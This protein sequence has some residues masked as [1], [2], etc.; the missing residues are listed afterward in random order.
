ME[1]EMF[2]DMSSKIDV[3]SEYEEWEHEYKRSNSVVVCLTMLLEF[4]AGEWIKAYEGQ[5][6]AKD[7]RV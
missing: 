7:W 3:F 4:S 2:R 6:W 5:L 1:K